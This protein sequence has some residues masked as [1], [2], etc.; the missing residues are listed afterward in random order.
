MVAVFAVF[1]TLSSIEF[2]QMGVGLA[3]AVLLDVTLVRGIA[4]PAAIT[5]LGEKGWR[6]PRLRARPRVSEGDRV[7]VPA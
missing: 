3:V 7:K 5:L 4:L 6:V 1:A 2:K